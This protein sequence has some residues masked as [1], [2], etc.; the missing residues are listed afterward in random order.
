MSVKNLRICTEKLSPYA[1]DKMDR[2]K[3][4]SNSHDHFKKLRAAFYIKKIWNRGA[5]IKIAFLTTGENV[6][7]TSISQIELHKSDDGTFLQMDPLQ[8]H[9]Q[10]MSAIDVVKTVVKTRIQPIVNL[11]IVFVDNPKNANIRI[12]FEDSGSWSLIGTDCL[13]EKGATMNFAWMDVATVCHEFGHAL[14]MIHEHQNLN[15]NPI[16]WDLEKLYKWGEETQGWSKTD[17]DDQIVNKYDLTLVNGST[18]D[19]LSVMLYFF[20]PELT[21]DKKGT[22]QNL[23]LS[24][25]DVEWIVKMYPDGPESPEDFYLKT[26]GQELSYAINL[27]LGIKNNMLPK[28]LILTVSVLSLVLVLFI[29]I[30]Y[31]MKNKN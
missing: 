29:Y 21:T 27:S 6:S 25:L 12:S 3:N 13:N 1:Q 9:I 26:Y 5:T 30:H 28:I 24:G 19:P 22:H 20:P 8:P 7:F 4:N 14:G 10:G 2:M 17:V 15:N 16:H 31:F 11:N 18:F 23:R